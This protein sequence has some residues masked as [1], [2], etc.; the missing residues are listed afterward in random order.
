MN[1][2]EFHKAAA[3]RLRRVRVS[4]GP[5]VDAALA[6]QPLMSRDYALAINAS[7]NVLREAMEAVFQS[8]LPQPPEYFGEMAVRLACYALTAL[9]PDLQETGA[10]EV[11]KHLLSKL[12]DMQANG[13]VIQTE[14]E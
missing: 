4:L 9:H 13:H 14:W 3:R 8:V 1:S 10:M 12:A 6:S 2:A 7:Q 11:R 5:N